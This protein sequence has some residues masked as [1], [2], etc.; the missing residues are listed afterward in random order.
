MLLLLS[1]AVS[2]GACEY[3][4]HRCRR[5]AAR[6]RVHSIIGVY[7][8][9]TVRLIVVRARARTFALARNCHVL[10]ARMA[11]W[12]IFF[13]STWSPCTVHD[14]MMTTHHRVYA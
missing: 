5:C 12:C 4:R 10:C 9:F 6:K 2:R 13:P 11:E 1:S 7:L 3:D 8:H 14:M